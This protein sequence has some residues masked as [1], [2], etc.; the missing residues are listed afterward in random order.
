MLGD[1][2]LIVE[3]NPTNLKLVRLLLDLE[4]YEVQVATN[5]DE[6]L[7]ILA[8]FHPQLILMDLQL[9]GKNGFDLM[10]DL[11]SDP[12]FKDV[13]FVAL[14]AYAMKGDEERARFIGFDGYMTKPISV[15]DFPKQIAQF[16]NTTKN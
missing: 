8:N 2:I 16:L 3:D 7:E 6:T 10:L 5:A 11:K 14:T 1:K 13:L 4:K 9:P 12:K 15:V